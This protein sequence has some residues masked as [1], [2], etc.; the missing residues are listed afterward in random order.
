MKKVVDTLK[1]PSE[2]QILQ[3]IELLHP[4]H[5][6]FSS[7][8]LQHKLNFIEGRQQKQKNLYLR[9]RSCRGQNSS[10]RHSCTEKKLFILRLE[11]AAA[12]VG[13]HR[14]GIK[15]SRR[16]ISGTYLAEVRIRHSCTEKSYSQIRAQLGLHRND[17]K[18]SR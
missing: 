12:E 3:R 9:Y 4:I 16:H 1:S 13:L 15:S 17:V 6:Y 11:Y 7:N 10:L 2:T 5:N 8:L 18:T 14:K